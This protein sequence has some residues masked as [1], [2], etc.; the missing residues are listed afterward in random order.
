MDKFSKQIKALYEQQVVIPDAMPAWHKLEQ[1]LETE[2]RRKVWYWI[3]PI[4]L[5]MGGFS[6]WQIGV[7]DEQEIVIESTS[8][9]R[10]ENN[11]LTLVKKDKQV[12]A[13]QQPHI[14]GQ[15]TELQKVEEDAPLNH[16]E[17]TSN[18]IQI[19]SIETN[20][21]QSDFATSSEVSGRGIS[22]PTVSF[23]QVQA[24]NTI[25]EENIF[26]KA[27]IKHMPEIRAVVSLLPIQRYIP[28]MKVTNMPLHALQQDAVTM[29][30]DMQRVQV[31]VTTSIYRLS[32]R[33]IQGSHG[34]FLNGLLHYQVA[35]RWKVTG[36]VGFGRYQLHTMINSVDLRIEGLQLRENN[37]TT[38]QITKQ[39]DQ[40]RLELDCMYAIINR[41][42][43]TVE[44]GPG[45]I[46]K[47]DLASS[48]TY[49]LNRDGSP[50]IEEIRKNEKYT[51]PIFG[52]ISIQGQLQLKG[53]W[54]LLMSPYFAKAILSNN[55]K[56]PSESG[57][58]FGVNKKF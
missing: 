14:N 28:G 35:N 46:S 50:V 53:N 33:F 40:F 56:H 4:V 41:P 30:D 9:K 15:I 23:C 22:T 7:D 13:A 39:V 21:N 24:G 10:L 29:G 58:H 51:Y 43:L 45:V 11:A 38:T 31:A 34:L 12:K 44:V 25:L 55:V 42:R 6:L 47:H 8:A 54:S 27:E 3:I 57:I 26:S 1:S 17:L 32:H 16:E 36:G 48:D 18:A 49:H 19:I 20:S 2:S 52:K 5:I 37:A